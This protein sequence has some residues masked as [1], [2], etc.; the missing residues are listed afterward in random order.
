MPSR[1][2][3]GQPN[4]ETWG[5]TPSLS[6][7]DRLPTALFEAG[8]RRMEAHKAAQLTMAETAEACTVAM[9]SCPSRRCRACPGVSRQNI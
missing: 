6:H 5:F 1:S 9:A 8:T 7:Q 4:G 2:D 3:Q